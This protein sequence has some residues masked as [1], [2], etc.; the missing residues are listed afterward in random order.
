MNFH[1]GNFH[2]HNARRLQAKLFIAIK[3]M[4]YAR[5]VVQL[6]RVRKKS[7]QAVLR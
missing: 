6:V 4:Y 1:D 5:L 7:L 2:R 3:Y